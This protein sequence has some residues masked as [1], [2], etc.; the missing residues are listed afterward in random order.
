[1]KCGACNNAISTLAINHVP[2]TQGTLAFNGVAL[3]CPVCRVVL[4][5]SLDLK[6][7]AADIAAAL[8]QARGP[9]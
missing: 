1:M 8:K 5:A 3:C 4:G 6:A 7:L 9:A 2:I